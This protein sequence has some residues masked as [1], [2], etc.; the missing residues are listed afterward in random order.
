M[1][2]IL[3]VL[4][5]A[6]AVAMPNPDAMRVELRDAHVTAT[7]AGGSVAVRTLLVNPTDSTLELVGV[8]T[9]LA[10]Q[11]VLQHY[12]KTRDGLY[13]TAPLNKL[14][15]APK[16]ETVLAPGALELQL[17]GVTK[18]LEAGRELPLTL[19]FADGTQRVV[20]VS[21]EVEGQ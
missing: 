17:V 18:P 5:M 12:V 3:P 6:A 21:V 14:V 2:A 7:E 4:A 8:T 11:T 9:P 19:K 20:R 13:Q 1:M 15:L 10:G 16:S